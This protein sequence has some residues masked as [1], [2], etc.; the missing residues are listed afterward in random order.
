MATDAGQLGLGPVA[1]GKRQRDVGNNNFLCLQVAKISPDYN[2][3][4]NV[5]VAPPKGETASGVTH[6]RA[7]HLV[8]GLDELFFWS[9]GAIALP[10]RSTLNGYSGT[11]FFRN[12]Q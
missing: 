1:V 7:R 8:V 2:M 10:G 6:F 3:M 9:T 11:S 5:L 4:T 12:Q